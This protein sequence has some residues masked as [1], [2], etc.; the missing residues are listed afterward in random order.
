MPGPQMDTRELEQR[1]QRWLDDRISNLPDDT[2]KISSEAPSEVHGQIIRLLPSN[3]EAAKVMVHFENPAQ[4][5]LTLGIG[6]HV[7]LYSK[8]VDQLESQFRGILDAVIDCGFEETVWRR[9]DRVLKSKGLL[10]LSGGTKKITYRNW[11][12]PGK[13]KRSK[14]HFVYRPF[15]PRD[16][17]L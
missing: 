17:V 6:C 9:G 14:S 2:F 7:E 1:F 10:R 5:D 4:I 13:G 11:A 15:S 3:P 8:D 12:S 16:A